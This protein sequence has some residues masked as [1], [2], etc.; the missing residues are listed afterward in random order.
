M[1]NVKEVDSILKPFVVGADPVASIHPRA[2]PKRQFRRNLPQEQILRAL[3][4]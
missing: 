3:F 2:H 4:P 1:S